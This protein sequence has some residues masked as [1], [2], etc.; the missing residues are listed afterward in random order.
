[1]TSTTP[2]V[3]IA[4]G[5]DQRVTYDAIDHASA[6]DAAVKCHGCGRV[7]LGRSRLSWYG[8]GE[9][10]L[11]FG[12]WRVDHVIAKTHWEMWTETV[13]HGCSVAYGKS[14][15]DSVCAL[16]RNGQEYTFIKTRIRVDG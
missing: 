9:H 12:W 5:A 7:T 16:T 2:P 13:A 15:R 11:L 1:V 10:S 6:T 4:A 3:L 14:E 8:L